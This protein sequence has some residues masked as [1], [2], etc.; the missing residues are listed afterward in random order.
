MDKEK[1]EGSGWTGKLSYTGVLELWRTCPVESLECRL[2]LLPSRGKGW[3]QSPEYKS[4]PSTP[5]PPFLPYFSPLLTLPLEL[6]NPHQ[7]HPA[8]AHPSRGVT[9]SSNLLTTTAL[10]KIPYK[11]LEDI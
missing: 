6:P 5:A 2:L 10:P 11:S 3:P 1:L 7:S 9:Y 4:T 8:Q